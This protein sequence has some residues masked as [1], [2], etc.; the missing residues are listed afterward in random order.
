MTSSD[1]K[2]VFLRIVQPGEVLGLHAVVSAQPYQ[3]S[4]ETLEPYQVS[5]IRRDDF[6][7]LLSA[8]AGNYGDVFP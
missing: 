1:G 6:L 3:A 2:T 4:A 8:A 7:R 5:F